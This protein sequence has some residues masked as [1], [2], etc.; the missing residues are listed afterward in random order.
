MRGS[1]IGF[2]A[3]KWPRLEKLCIS[4]GPKYAE[5]DPEAAPLLTAEQEALLTGALLKRK[6]QLKSWF[7]NETSKLKRAGRGGGTAP[8]ASLAGLL[9]KARAKRRRHHQVLEVYQKR[10]AER[11]K[12]RLAVRG[13]NKLN[14][15]T[16]ARD[17]EGEWIDDDDSEA[18]MIRVRDASVARMKLTRE[19]VKEMFDEETQATQDEYRKWAKEEVLPQIEDT[20]EGG[21]R[22]PEEYQAS[23]DESGEVVR[24][25]HDM[26]YKMT[27]WMGV[28]V[29][30][31]PMPNMGGEL[32]VKAIPF[33]LTPGGVHFENWHP[34][35]TKSVSKPLLR[36]LRRAIRE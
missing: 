3:T 6:E 25:F 13:F 24:L 14:E 7:R 17:K 29:F 12:E 21:K 19:V 4:F 2:L 36:F 5:V 8:R 33:G 27:G 22:R 20:P 1:K 18:R 26:L 15:A 9:F 31:G 10:N 34:S 16:Q 30:G 32:A 28:T 35:W 23:I 11:L